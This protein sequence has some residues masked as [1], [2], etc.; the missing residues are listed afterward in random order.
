MVIYGPMETCGT[1]HV[2][3]QRFYGSFHC[4][5]GSSG[6][7]R[8]CSGR[9]HGDR[10]K[11]W[12]LLGKCRW[13]LLW[14]LLQKVEAS[15]STSIMEDPIV[16]T[17]ASTKFYWKFNFP[18]FHYSHVSFHYRQLPLRL[19]LHPGSME[20]STTSIFHNFHESFR[21]IP[22]A[23]TSM[24]AGSFHL[25]PWALEASTTSSKA[26]ATEASTYFHHGSFHVLNDRGIPHFGMFVF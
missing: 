1:F 10:W 7:F 21:R 13:Q 8:R 23:S 24:E 3:F 16:F 9:L 2:S 26:S 11:W 15:I 18:P 25:F 20:A 5:R 12:K 4:F 22:S 14:K 19:S 17:D 6:S